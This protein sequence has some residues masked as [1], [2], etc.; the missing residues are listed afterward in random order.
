[1]KKPE[2]LIPKKFDVLMID[3][4]HEARHVEKILYNYYPKLNKDGL[5]IV[6]DISWLYYTPKAQRDNFNIEIN[7]RETFFKLI[8]IFN[9]NMQ[10]INLELNFAHSGVCKIIKKNDQALNSPV[11]IKSREFSIKNFIKNIIKND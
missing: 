7:N 6:D 2:K 5:V 10:N 8:E 3:T 1:M 4:L 11:K 9:S